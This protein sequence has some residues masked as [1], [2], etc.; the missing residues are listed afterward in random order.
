MTQGAL[1]R[2]VADCQ[3]LYMQAKQPRSDRLYMT[4]LDTGR[5][6]HVY[7]FPGTPKQYFPDEGFEGSGRD[8][9]STDNPMSPRPAHNSSR[10]V[11]VNTEMPSRQRPNMKLTWTFQSIVP[12]W[13]WYSFSVRYLPW[14]PKGLR[15]LRPPK[16]AQT[17]QLLMPRIPRAHAGLIPKNY[18]KAYEDQPAT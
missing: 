8:K 5:C 6:S 2:N 17:S 1:I 3:A 16:V 18:I 4:T 14:N 10:R 15:Y 12:C 7:M 9:P 13:I 11:S